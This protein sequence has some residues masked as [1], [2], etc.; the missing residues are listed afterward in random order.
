MMKLQSINSEYQRRPTRIFT[1]NTNSPSG[2]L[3]SSSIKS[4]LATSNNNTSRLK[5]STITKV[6]P[7]NK[8]RLKQHIVKNIQ[9]NS[10]S[11]QTQNDPDQSKFLSKL[12]K[13]TAIR[14][15]PTSLALKS[16]QDQQSSRKIPTKLCT[17]STLPKLQTNLGANDVSCIETDNNCTKTSPRFS[18]SSESTINTKS[19][20]LSGVR[21]QDL[22]K[23]KTSIIRQGKLIS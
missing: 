9:T 22:F 11:T 18:S 1:E 6:P 20:S 14:V 8:S 5:C 23:R 2:T 12:A 4:R 19:L 15:R 10:N 13:P 7:A 3:N 17:T 16:P 21:T